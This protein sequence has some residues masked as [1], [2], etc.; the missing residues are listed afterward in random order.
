MHK[1]YL[2]AF[3]I[4]SVF[5]Q[6]IRA[7]T[8]FVVNDVIAADPSAS[9]IDPEYN[10]ALNMVCWQSEEKELWVCMLDPITHLYSPPDGK[11]VLIDQD[12]TPPTF[13]GWNGPEWLLSQGTTQIIY[14]QKKGGVRYPGLATQVLGG[15]SSTTLMQ[16]PDALYAM[17]TRNYADS[18]GLFLFESQSNDGIRWVS[19]SDL[20]DCHFYPDI[21]LGFFADDNQQICCA[22]DHSRQPGFLEV[23]TTLPFFTQISNDTIGAPSMWNDPET[24]SRMFMYRTNG[25]KT[26]KIF[27]ENSDGNWYLYHSFNSPLPAPYEYITSPEP[28]V[29]GG[30]SYISFMAAQSPMGLSEEPAEIWIASI[31]PAERLMRRV[32]DSTVAIRVDPEPVIIGDSAFVYYTEKVHTLWWYHVHRVRKCS[33]GL[34]STYTGIA[35]HDKNES[36]ITISPNPCRETLKFTTSF[37]EGSEISVLIND[38]GGNSVRSAKVFSNRNSLDIS[39]LSPGFYFL[40]LNCNGR[41]STKQFIVQ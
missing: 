33:T 4:L 8:P 13:G 1:R 12:L 11:G 16:Y 6:I 41:K 36:E 39:D 30:K 2:L 21:T 9:I 10:M 40:N 31:N 17:A 15:W 23:A 22:I 7:Q 32:S 26:L 37:P 29:F 38:A 3:L 27:Q 18:S 35:R 14:N 34:E 20:N 25:F 28:F 5:T 24:N 19:N